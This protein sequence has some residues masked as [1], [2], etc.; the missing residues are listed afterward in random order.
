MS[1]YFVSP[2]LGERFYH[3]S[4]DLVLKRDSDL[5][6]RIEKLAKA[7]GCSFDK[8]VESVVEVGL[9]HHIKDN[10]QFRED[11]AQR[12]ALQNLLEEPEEE[13]EL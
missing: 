4:I 9:S 7:E 2:E 3:Q 6:R 1:E 12:R 8:M 10:L 13:L 5:F 11:C